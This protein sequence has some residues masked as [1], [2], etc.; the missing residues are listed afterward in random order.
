MGYG[1]NQVSGNI[2]LAYL[3]SL[4]IKINWRDLM[5]EAKLPLLQQSVFLVFNRQIIP[6][7]KEVTWFGRQLIMT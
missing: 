3:V 7:E 6:L 4:L 1:I 5:N 2:P